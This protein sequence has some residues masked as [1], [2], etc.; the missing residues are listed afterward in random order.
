MWIS[1]NSLPAGDVSLQSERVLHQ[2]LAYLAD[3]RIA[4][5]CSLFSSAFLAVTLV[6][7]N[8]PPRSA[9]APVL[10]WDIDLTLA[11]A[12]RRNIGTTGDPLKAS[13]GKT[14]STNGLIDFHASGSEN[15]PLS[16]V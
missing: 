6:Q 7:K 3:A 5:F 14:P 12:L 1:K 2:F 16:G 11:R 4:T 13:D 8:P 15:L 9:D 10:I